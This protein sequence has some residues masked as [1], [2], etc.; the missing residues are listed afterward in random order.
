[1]I[2]S[3]M[4]VVLDCRHVQDMVQQ[5]VQLDKDRAMLVADAQSLHDS[6]HELCSLRG[7]IAEE[8]NLL[9]TGLQHLRALQQQ[10]SLEQTAVKQQ[11]AAVADAEGK[12]QQLQVQISEKQA[13]L[14]KQSLKA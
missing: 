13:E 14:S 3:S 2:F 9:S 11:S 4:Q 6:T 5:R 8:K 10:T 7:A 1:M 12:L